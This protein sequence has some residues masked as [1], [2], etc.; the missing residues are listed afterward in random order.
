MCTVKEH[1]LNSGTK[2]VVAGAGG[3]DRA[4]DGKSGGVGGGGKCIYCETECVMAIQGHPSLLI[5]APIESTYATS[6]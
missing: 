1:H 3:G 2:T 4:G 5:L 6:Y